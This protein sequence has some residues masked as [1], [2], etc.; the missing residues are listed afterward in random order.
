MALANT[1]FCKSG[2]V[3]SSDRKVFCKFIASLNRPRSR[4][5]FEEKQ[6]YPTF[7]NVPIPPKPVFNIVGFDSRPGGLARPALG[8][9]AD[10]GEGVVTARWLQEKILSG[11]ADKKHFAGTLRCS[12]RSPRPFLF[13]SSLTFNADEMAN[14][15]A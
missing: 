11:Y 10:L 8:A 3:H 6:H 7:I 12:Q 4:L 2:I 9:A 13:S 15:S 1:S 14:I 5:Q